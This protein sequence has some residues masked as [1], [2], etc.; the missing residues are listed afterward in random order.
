[1]LFYRLVC[2]SKSIIKS[3]HSNTAIDHAP[4]MGGAAHIHIIRTNTC[5]NHIT[6]M[7]QLT[8]PAIPTIPQ[9]TILTKSITLISVLYTMYMY[10]YMY[11]MYRST[12]C[13]M[14]C[15]C[16]C[17]VSGVQGASGATSATRRPHPQCRGQQEHLWKYS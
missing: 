9:L 3:C 14:L 8:T 13:V 2:F 16:L 6:G 17:D 1:M 12:V 10:T 15:V 11:L 5:T 4:T 7:A